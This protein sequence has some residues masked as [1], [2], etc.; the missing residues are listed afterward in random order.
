VHAKILDE[1]L[2]ENDYF[3]DHPKMEKEMASGS[4]ESAGGGG[5]GGIVDEIAGECEKLAKNTMGAQEAA[6]AAPVTPYIPPETESTPASI[7]E[8]TVSTPSVPESAP[9]EIPTPAVEF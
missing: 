7:P 2:R 8:P 3:V 9:V 5:L 4:G 6:P 1:A